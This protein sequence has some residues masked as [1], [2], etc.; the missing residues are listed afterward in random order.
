VLG[1]R[2]APLPQVELMPFLLPGAPSS[3]SGGQLSLP[4]SLQTVGCVSKVSTAPAPPTSTPTPGP[5]CSSEELEKAVGLRC[6]ANSFV[7]LDELPDFSVPP[8]SCAT[9][10]L[11]LAEPQNS[12]RAALRCAWCGIRSRSPARL[13]EPVHLADS[14][15]LGP[16]VFST[17]SCL[18][19][20]GSGPRSPSYHS[21]QFPGDGSPVPSRPAA[22]A[23]S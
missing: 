14:Q 1:Y 9:S 23:P 3:W 2:P 4:L 5:A 10:W 8:S 13:G 16:G 15:A 18:S 19:P 11:S 17:C 12:S 21:Q 6:S 22:S 20:S 7:T